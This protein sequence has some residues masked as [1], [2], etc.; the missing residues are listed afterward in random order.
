[1]K[2]MFA[3][4]WWPFPIAETPRTLWIE[5]TSKCPFDCVFCSRKTRRGSGEHLPFPVYEAL[6]GQLVDPRTLILN[7][8]G[9]STVYPELIPAI[10][11]ARSAGAFVEL[12]SALA[13]APES[14]LSALSKSGLNRLTVSLHATD[15]QQYAEIYRHSSFGILRDRLERFVALC[16]EAPHPPIVDLSFVAMDRNLT[17]LPAVADFASSLGLGEI[18]IFP[19]MRRDEIPIQLPQELTQLGMHRP[20][21]EERVKGTVRE[22]R[23]S[24]PG[25]RFTIC[26]PSFS[27]GTACLGEVP[28]A[29]PGLLPPDARVYSCEQNPW[30]TAHVLSNGDVVACEVLD[31]VPLG[32]LQRQSLTDIWHGKQYEQFR[33]RYQSG[34]VPECRACAWKKAFRPGPLRSDILGSRGRSAQLLSGWH[35]PSG[36]A[37]V[38]SSQQAAAVIAPRTGSRSIHL[39]GTLP[40]GPKGQANALM[41]HCN[42]SEIGRI[43]NPWEESIPF[44]LDFPVADSQ[45]DPWRIEFRTRHVYRPNE[46]G[47]GTDQRDLGFA[48]TLL[49]SK[50]YDDPETASRHEQAL[51]P[52]VRA[53]RSIDKFGKELRLLTRR[54]LETRRAPTPETHDAGLDDPGITVVIPERDNP[55]ELRAC[56]ES[57]R[58]AGR[59][60]PEP[61]QTMVIVNGSPALDYEPLRRANPAVEWRFHAQPLGFGGAI[62]AGLREARFPWVYLLNNDVVLDRDAFRALAPCRNRSIFGI[63][64]QIFLKDRT[65]FREET[66]WTA[67]LIQDGLAVIH[68][69]IPRSDRPVENFY[70]GGGASLFQASLLRRFLEPSAYAPFYWEDVEWGWR[71]RKLGYR[72]LFCPQSVAHHRQQATIRRCYSA[73]DIETVLERNRLMFQLRNLTSAGSLDRVVA[74]IARSPKAVVNDFMGAPMRWKVARGRLWNHLAPLTDEEVLS[75]WQRAVSNC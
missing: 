54:L 44:G 20:E 10:Q 11:L 56:L 30:E 60:F 45:A 31:K 33:R 24:H 74:E 26:N 14:M 18:L 73:G 50:R 48:L 53:I 63:S 65:R 38:W 7:Y 15:P 68:D 67:L 71:A 5:L 43:V 55:E 64:S 3:Q 70:A 49:A 51:Q 2:L 59:H 58:E 22:A 61:L 12:V 69:W 41:V 23:Q 52:M 46:R 72:C 13:S 19:V 62:R 36:E 1:M 27:E 17:E 66:N 9:E 32:S 21:F 4:G 57:V 42:G 25:V 16:G 47:A 35:D 29:W 40:P 39:S 6:I 28:G 75:S 8:S 34:E 37:H